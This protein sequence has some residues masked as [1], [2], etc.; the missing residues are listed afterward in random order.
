MMRFSWTGVLVAP[1]LAPLLFSTM[2]VT[3]LGDDNPLFGFLVLFV[4][5]CIISYFGT[6]FLFLPCLLVISLWRPLT[7]FLVGLLGLALG[8]S[9]FVPL[10]LMAWK[11][12]G[13]DSGPPVDN[14][15]VY[16]CRSLTEPF[17]AS[18]PVAG[19]IAAGAYWGFG[20]W[21]NRRPRPPTSGN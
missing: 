18:Y 9:L 4:P 6:V 1:L 15:L 5:S 11:S 10:A 20:T 21:R 13:P 8:A 16:F 2:V 12:S 14:F 3:L 7:G 17:T 19:L